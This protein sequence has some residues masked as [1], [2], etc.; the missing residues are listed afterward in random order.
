MSLRRL[1]RSSNLQM[2]I[3]LKTCRPMQEKNF[4][5]K[6]FRIWW[7][8][9]TFIIF[10]HLG[11]PKPVL[12]ND[13]IEPSNQNCTNI[14]Q[15]LTCWSMWTSYPNSCINTIIPIIKVFECLQPK[16]HLSTPK[17]SGTICMAS[18]PKRRR[19]NHQLLKWGIK[20]DWIKIQTVQKRIL[21]WMDRRSVCG[22]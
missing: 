7:N 9:R 6:S 21:T 8:N 15:Q 18:I 14:L 11:V 12:W 3:N 13:S 22:T 19:K 10:L 1:L 5:I 20:C 4:T 16:S 17:K 2:D